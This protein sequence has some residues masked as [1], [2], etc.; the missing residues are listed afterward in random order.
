MK[1]RAS[2]Q[3]MTAV[4]FERVEW[5]VHQARQR[6]GSLT[7]SQA[8]SQAIDGDA[9]ARGLYARRRP[10]RKAGTETSAETRSREHGPRAYLRVPG[11]DGAPGGVLVEVARLRSLTAGTSYD[12]ELKAV[13]RDYPNLA[14]FCEKDG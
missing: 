2:D 12:D 5:A 4:W 7:Q 3:D 14:S 10:I 8:L 13:M 9:E 1:Q 11:P 6:D